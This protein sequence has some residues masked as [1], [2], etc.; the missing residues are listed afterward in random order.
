[1]DKAV[2][3]SEAVLSLDTL[4]ELINEEHTQ[5]Q[6]A[7]R[8]GLSH[9]LRAGELLRQA[10][11]RCDHGAWLPWLEANFDGS[12]RTA[13]G[14]M[15]VARNWPMLEAANS[16]HVSHLPYRDALRLLAEPHDSEPGDDLI[17]TARRAIGSLE[18]TWGALK[19][20]PASHATLA[21]LTA[22]ASK[23]QEWQNRCAE[24]TLRAE[25]R[26]GSLL[27]DLTDRLIALGMSES[28]AKSLLENPAALA[29]ACAVHPAVG[30]A[31]E[32]V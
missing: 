1:M 17:R 31:S 11:E 32:A 12:T 3:P 25:R 26:A 21:E 10:K 29:A 28:E 4:A 8:Q 24:M 23:A 19:D 7:V 20:A 30:L 9:A 13:Q 18:A 16:Q 2:V 15:S 14:Y 22:L 6:L 27:G 5:C